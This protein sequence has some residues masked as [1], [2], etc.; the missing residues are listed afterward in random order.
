MSKKLNLLGQRFGRLT[1]IEK[2]PSKN[3]SGQLKTRWVCK[4]DCGNIVTVTTQ[5]LRKGDTKSCGCLAIEE[6]KVRSIKHGKRNT[7][8]YK[9]WANMKARCYN[10]NE[11]NYYLYGG[12]GIEVCDSWK[13]SFIE[14]YTW[15]ID[16]G[17][18]SN[19]TLDRKNVDGN[20]EPNNC[21]WANKEQQ[22]N[23]TRTNVYLEYE[24]I[25]HTIA[26]WAKIKNIPYNLLWNRI[27]KSHWDIEKAFTEPIQKSKSHSKKN[28][29]G[30]LY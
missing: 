30:G 23:N 16:N 19:L 26:E 25:T 6:L 1:V 29:N 13:N 9:I 5:E 15:A 10:P 24:G 12:R 20:Y 14:F 17:Y 18:Q 22:A 28:K 4:C 3:Y 21:R 27:N 2:A 8:I 11:I 7:R